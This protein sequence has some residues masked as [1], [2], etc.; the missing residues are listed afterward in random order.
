[1]K[2]QIYKYKKVLTVS[3][4][5]ILFCI[6]NLVAKPGNHSS[7]IGLVLG[8][9]TGFS[10]KFSDTGSTHF[11][12]ALSWSLKKETNLY[13]HT[14]YIFKRFSPV[15]FSPKFSMTPTMGIGGRIETK[16]G[17]LGLR[18]PLGLYHKFK[19]NLFDLFIEL[20]PTLNL[21]PK[22][23]FEIGA[24]LAVRYLF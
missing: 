12:A 20:A 19:E 15:H 5:L 7:G 16:E 1:M 2:M 18:I 3:F 23:D 8:N 11:N 21:V 17:E 4:L 6:S 14:D 10:F 13:L 9:P 24:A 22:T